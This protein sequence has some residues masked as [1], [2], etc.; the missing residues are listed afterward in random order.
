MTGAEATLIGAIVGGGTAV[1]AAAVATIC[2]Y[3]VTKRS[4][5]A[6]AAQKREERMQQRIELAYTEILTYLSNSIAHV[7]LCMTH[8]A[9][10]LDSE[11]PSAPSL[12]PSRR[13]AAQL[14]SSALVRRGWAGFESKMTSFGGYVLLY[15]SHK[16]D[17]IAGLPDALKGSG[18]PALGW[19][20]PHPTCETWQTCSLT[21]CTASSRRP[22]PN[23]HRSGRP[24][25][26]S[27]SAL[28]AMKSRLSVFSSK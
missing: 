9:D 14:H 10:D 7:D 24:R 3:K 12:E 5:D 2:T 6:D 17:T 25:S 15:R 27:P 20:R 4:I 19:R 1:L 22:P 8:S 13:A 11:I 21:R 26:H 16:K 28:R 23:P 18:P